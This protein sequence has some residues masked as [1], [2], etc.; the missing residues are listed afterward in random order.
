MGFFSKR[1][2]VLDLTEDYKY[3]SRERKEVSEPLSNQTQEGSSQSDGSAGNFFNWFG[4]S[5]SQESSSTS[6]SSYPNTYSSSGTGEGGL[7]AE[8]RR[9]RLAKRLKDMTDKLEEI[10]NQLY[11]LQQRVEVLEKKIR[12]NSYE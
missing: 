10:S 2:K 7:D 12:V 9:K 8:E 11:L 1:G 5:G 6:G 3:K 4:G